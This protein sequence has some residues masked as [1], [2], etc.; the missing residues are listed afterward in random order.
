MGAGASTNQAWTNSV[1]A[2]PQILDGLNYLSGDDRFRFL[3]LKYI[4]GGDWVARLEEVLTDAKLNGRKCNSKFISHDSCWLGYAM[5]ED[6]VDGLTTCSYPSGSRELPNRGKSFA[7]AHMPSTRSFSFRPEKSFETPAK[8]EPATLSQQQLT[9]I[10]LSIL[11]PLFASTSDDEDTNAPANASARHNGQKLARIDSSPSEKPETTRA[12]DILRGCCEHYA[13]SQTEL[14]E[15][16]VNTNWVETAFE[17]IKHTPLGVTI[18]DTSKEGSP[19]LFANAAFK[20]MTGYKRSEMQGKN[21]SVL[22][23]ASTEL[24]QAALLEEAVKNGYTAKIAVTYHH[25]NK[26]AFLD[27]IA[28]R[29]CAQYSVMVHFAATKHSRQ[30]DLLVSG[31]YPEFFT[32]QFS[33]HAYR[34]FCFCVSV[35]F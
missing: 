8:A 24:G 34:P 22:H 9:A 14:D 13:A 19:L 27:L 5:D 26:K 6:A 21:F 29:A 3:F 10:M 7:F 15:V 23:G 32:L 31:S 17:A 4:S 16:L 11:Y 25:K 1:F 20:A 28:V 30:E 12:Q 33:C 18:C 2:N 35:F